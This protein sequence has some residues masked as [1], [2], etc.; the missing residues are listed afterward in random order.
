MNF[1]KM[2]GI[3]TIVI[4]SIFSLMLTTSYAWYS[5]ENA[6]TKFD[7]VTADDK[8]EI[9]YQMGEYINTDSAIPIKSSDVDLFS[10][11]YDFS[12]RVK[13][14][15]SGN[16]MIAKI[17]LAGIVIDDELKKVDDVLGDSPFRVD[18]FYQGSQVGNTITGKNFN[19]ET[20]EIGDVYLSSDVDNQFELRVYL[21]DN[22]KDQSNL[23]N[24]RFQAKIDVNV[25]SRV[26]TSFTDFKDPDII[27]SSIKVDGVF[28]KYLPNNGLYDMK[29][30]CKKGSK[31]SW[32]KM[33]KTLIYDN[34]SFI[35]DECSLE[36]ISS[37]DKIYLRDMDIGSYV[38]FVGNNGCN[39]DS[40]NGINPNYVSLD[41]MGYCLDSNYHFMSSG[42]RIL[43][44]LDNT[45]YLTSA[46]AV[47]CGD[48]DFDSISLKY[49]N[50]GFAYG[51][52]C[53][54]NSVWAFRES[55]LDIVKN[56]GVY[57]NDLLDIGS[58]YGYFD[59]L[60]KFH[61]WNPKIRDFEE[62]DEV[63]SIGIRPVIRLKKD[64]LVVGGMGTYS[65]PYIIR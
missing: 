44:I 9:V 1:R 58:Y 37:S 40:C 28:S 61:V 50:I 26:N 17:S 22:G 15:V 20:F 56:N 13:K 4:I 27:I 38:E 19:E 51:G 49:C 24:K 53:N 14:K 3:I 12:I 59:S 29:S 16:D 18:F 6:S 25:V 54:S 30:S 47:E 31:V 57:N 48:K 46:G 36:F 8:V 33:N 10:D 5:Y 2:L 64:V 65:D 34:K 62:V 39:G 32:D 23:M 63:S 52:K 11:K 55:D 21:L 60:D 35:H 41:D 42:Y 43:Y 45:V 7:V